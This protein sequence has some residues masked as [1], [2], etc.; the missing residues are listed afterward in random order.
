MKSSREG[1]RCWRRW[2]RGVLRPGRGA[3]LRGA[4]TRR[5]PA[6]ATFDLPSGQV[7]FSH[8][9]R[10]RR[11]PR[12]NSSWDEFTLERFTECRSALARR[13]RRSRIALAA[14]AR[15]KWTSRTNR[16]ILGCPGAGGPSRGSHG[17]H[18]GP[19]VGCLGKRLRR[20]KKHVPQAASRPE[21]RD[22][23]PRGGPAWHGRARYLSWP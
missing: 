23:S 4:G 18:D 13:G 7:D 21:V 5:T 15:G 10:D 3:R 20:E 22:L 14:C 19:D 11:L 1:R 17:P 16:W 6:R 9:L 12:R 8:E 2:G